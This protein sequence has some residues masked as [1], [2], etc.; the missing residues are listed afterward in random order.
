MCET[1]R[2]LSARA[3]PSEVWDIG[4]LLGQW[5]II[6]PEG[7]DPTAGSDGSSPRAWQNSEKSPEAM[8]PVSPAYSQDLNQGSGG[9]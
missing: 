7:Q 1:L 2:S 4:S 9:R 8:G 6:V 3:Y 5:L